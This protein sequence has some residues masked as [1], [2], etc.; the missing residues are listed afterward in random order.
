MISS[1]RIWTVFSIRKTDTAGRGDCRAELK[2]LRCYDGTVGKREAPV[3]AK[4]S[5]FGEADR[6]A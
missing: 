6:S 2:L 4:F 1:I 3:N 5:P